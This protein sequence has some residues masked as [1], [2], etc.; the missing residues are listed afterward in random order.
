MTWTKLGDE[1]GDECRDLS[2]AAFRTHVEGLLWTMRRETGGWFDARDV[3]RFAESPHAGAAVDELVAA[4]WWSVDGQGYRINHAMRWQVEP[5]VLAKRRELDAERQRRHRQKKAGLSQRDAT[6]DPG[7]VGA[8][9]DGT[10]KDAYE[11]KKD[12]RAKSEQEVP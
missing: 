9:L 3:R 7:L 4:G 12:T 10:G 6:R 2:D 5:E 8:G 1:F 11:K